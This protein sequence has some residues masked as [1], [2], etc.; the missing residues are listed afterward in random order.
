MLF[1]LRSSVIHS[2]SRSSHRKKRSKQKS[3][4]KKPLE[5]WRLHTHTSLTSMLVHE[6]PFDLHNSFLSLC[7]A[8]FVFSDGFKGYQRRRRAPVYTKKPNVLNIESKSVLLRNK[9]LFRSA[10]NIKLWSWSWFW[11]ELRFKAILCLIPSDLKKFWSNLHLSN[12]RF[13]ETKQ[14]W[15]NSSFVQLRESWLQNLCWNFAEV[16]NCT[17]CQYSHDFEVSRF[18]H[19]RTRF[20]SMP[21]KMR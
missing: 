7:F 11:W 9:L 3:E 1:T 12:A 20:M 21:M 17:S 16:H 18:M 4:S 15:A 6:T 14:L 2:I 8:P 19:W 13:L 5:R 10:Y